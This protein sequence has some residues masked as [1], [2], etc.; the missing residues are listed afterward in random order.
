MSSPP[1]GKRE[2]VHGGALGFPF[3]PTVCSIHRQRCLVRICSSRPLSSSSFRPRPTV[4]GRRSAHLAL[5]LLHCFYA[6]PNFAVAGSIFDKYVKRKKLDPLET[7]VPAVLLTEEQFKDLEKYLDNEQPKFDVSRSLLRTG[8]AA[9]LR[10]NI[11]AVAQY[12]ADYGKGK[13]ASDAVDRCLRALEDLDS[14]LLHA[15]RNDP[16][17]TVQSMKGKITIALESLDSLLQTVPS[18]VIDKGKAIADA[19]LI[20]DSSVEEDPDL[21]KLEAIL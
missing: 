19:Y 8:P 13:T 21:R 4:I 14:L 15:S 11:R 6:Y 3:S 2:I 10:I 18:S 12:A 1:L 5:L 7:Y 16:S 9:S 17:A 20:P